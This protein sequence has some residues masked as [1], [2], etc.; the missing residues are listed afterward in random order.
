MYYRF[1]DHFAL[2][3]CA[4][5]GEDF[6]IVAQLDGLKGS[7]VPGGDP[8]RTPLLDR[9]FNI[10]ESFTDGEPVLSLTELAL[11][12]DLPKATA[13]RLARRLVELGALVRTSDNR[14]HLGMRLFELGALVPLPRLLREAAR[15]CL[16]DLFAAFNETVHLAVLDGAEVLYI[17]RIDGHSASRLPSRVGGRFPAHASAIGKA[18][19]AFSAAASSPGP[20]QLRRTGPRTVVQQPIL[21]QQ[22]AQIRRDGFAVEYEESARGICCVGAPILG[23]TG[24]LISAVSVAGSVHRMDTQRVVQAVRR[25][26]AGIS[27]ALADSE[28]LVASA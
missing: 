7:D 20:R 22:L 17:D 21:E 12:A 18:L 1:T 19:L 2:P 10:L 28:Q 15:P 25:A 11:R 27:T 6:G 3:L 16:E 23:A 14:Y 5:Q 24:T 8:Q 9:A 13:H 4:V 26:A